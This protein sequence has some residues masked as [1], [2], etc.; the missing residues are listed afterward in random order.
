MRDGV[1]SMSDQMVPRFALGEAGV[2]GH[3]SMEAIFGTEVADIIEHGR[4]DIAR[5]GRHEPIC[6]GR[7][8]IRGEVYACD[9]H[10]DHQGWAHSSSEALAITRLARLMAL[11]IWE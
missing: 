4:G 7:L 3:H 8:A 6:E 9:L 11:A 10:P 5:H 1:V 2:V